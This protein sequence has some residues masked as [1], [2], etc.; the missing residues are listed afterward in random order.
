MSVYLRPECTGRGIGRVAM[1]YLEA[2]AR[3]ARI[4]VLIGTM[5]QENSASIRLMEKSGFLKCAHL[6]N[7][8]EKFGKVLD[9]VV[10]EKEL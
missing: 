3:K 4:H 9:V 8:G 2:A 5:S 6:K 10:Y 1:E 7:V